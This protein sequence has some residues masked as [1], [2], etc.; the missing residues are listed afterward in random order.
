MSYFVYKPLSEVWKMR[1]RDIEKYLREQVKK[2]KGIAYKF[3]SPGH[4]GV[5]DRL[6]LIPNGK[7]T[8]IELKAPGKKPTALQLAQ[9]RKITKLGFPV[10]VIDSKE[11]V[12]R[13]IVEVAAG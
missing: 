1:E 5:P 13:F 9:H 11:G 3:E 12:D 8:F 2:I 10:L 6:V 7:M 4:A